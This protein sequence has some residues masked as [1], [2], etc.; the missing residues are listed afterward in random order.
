MNRRAHSRRKT[1]A[2]PFPASEPLHIEQLES[3]VYLGSTLDVLGYALFGSSLAFLTW[4][5]M[6]AA[7][8]GRWA[9]RGSLGGAP[10]AQAGHAN[11]RLTEVALVKPPVLWSPPEPLHSGVTIP[12][13]FGETTTS[14]AAR[15]TDLLADLMALD[16]ERPRL[17]FSGFG[18]PGIVAP[19]PSQEASG[20]GS[21]ADAGFFPPP[22]PVVGPLRAGDGQDYGWVGSLGKRR[23]SSAPLL[24]PA[25]LPS[26]GAGQIPSDLDSPGNNGRAGPGPGDGNGGDPRTTLA[27]PAQQPLLFE[28]N[29][30]QT[31]PSVR[32]VARAPGFNIFLRNTDAV[33]TIP[34][35]ASRSLPW[36]VLGVQF[37]NANPASVPVASKLQPGVS[38]YFLGNDRSHWATGVP[39]Y[40]QVEF[41]NLYP[42]INLVY[43]GSNLRQLEYDFVVA[44]GADPG[45]IRLGFQ[46]ATSVTMDGGGN[47]LLGTAAGT[48]TKR[49]P[50][51]YQTV[52]G[53]R[54]GVPTNYVMDTNGQVHL[55]VGS[56]DRR[57]PLVIDPVLSYSSYLGGS[58][59]DWGNGI[60]VDGRGDTYV[61]GQTESTNFPTAYPLYQ[62]RQGI[63]S[64]FVTKVDPSGSTLIYSTY[65]GGT[66]TTNVYSNPT[67]GGDSI[68]VDALGNAY[69][70]GGT[71]TDNFPTIG[72]S[73]TTPAG[74]FVTKLDPSGGLQNGAP[75]YSTYLGGV[76]SG[77]MTAPE[78]GVLGIAVDT[79]GDAYVTG[80]TPLDNFP[81]TA[82]AFQTRKPSVYPALSAFV[83]KFNPA[84]SALVYST[85]L[86]GS[87]NSSGGFGSDNGQGI[88]VDAAGNAYIT[89]NAQSTDFPTTSGAFQIT[90][91]DGQSAFVTKLNGTG[92][93]LVY[94]TFLGGSGYEWGWGIA[95]DG[96]GNAYVTGRTQSADFPTTSGAFQ[97]TLRGTED[98]FVTKLNGTG[99]APLV[100]STYLGG[101]GGDSGYGIAVDGLGNAYV[102]GSTNSTNFPTDNALQTGLVGTSS[103]DAFVTK[104]NATG[105]APVYSTY[106]GGSSDRHHDLGEAIAVDSGGSAYIT[107]STDST[108]FPTTPGAFEPMRGGGGD[109]FV[110]S[111]S[112]APLQRLHGTDS[113]WLDVGTAQVAPNTGTLRLSNPLDFRQSPDSAQ[114]DSAGLGIAPALVYNS[115]TVNVRPIAEVT[116]QFDQSLGLPT[117]IHVDLYWNGV[118]QGMGQ[119]FSTSG[120]QAGDIY[121]LAAELPA[122]TRVTATDRDAWQVI[123]TGHFGTQPDVSLSYAGYAQVVVTDSNDSTSRDD[124][125]FGPGWSLA[126]LNR[127]VFPSVGPA[128]VLMVYGDGTSSHFFTQILGSNNNTTI[129]FASPPDDFGTL[130]LNSINNTYT[131]TSK[132]QVK[133]NYDSTGLLKSIIDPHGLAVTFTYDATGRLLN[134]IQMPDSGPTGVVTTFLYNNGLLREID[135]PGGRTLVIARSGS[136]LGAITNPDGYVHTFL[137]DNTNSDNLHHVTQEMWNPATASYS[138]D[139][140]TRELSQVDRGQGVTLGITP[141]NI[142]GL[143]SPALFSGQAIASTTDALGHTTSYTLDIPGRITQLQRPGVL[144]PERWSRDPSGLVATHIDGDNHITVN[145]YSYGTGAGDLTETDYADGGSDHYQYDPVF[146][147]LTFRQDPL[148]HITSYTYDPMFGDLLTVTDPLTHVTSYTWNNGL[149]QSVVDPNVHTT[150][151]S[152]YP[153]TRLLSVVTDPRGYSTNYQYDGAGNATLTT[154]AR[155]NA[156]TTLYDKMRRLVQQTNADMGNYTYTY[157]GLGEMTSRQ[158]ALGMTTYNYDSRGWQTQVISARGK[159]TSSVY[160][161]AGN[162]TQ[163]IDPRLDAM[164]HPLYTTIYAYDNANRRTQV[165]DAAHNN[166][167]YVYDDADNLTQVIDGNSH[168]TTYSYDGRNRRTAVI[169]ALSHTTLYNY[170]KAGN[171]TK[172]TDPNSNATC[173]LYD[174]A[175]RRTA[176]QD[177]LGNSTTYAYDN[178]GN[179]TQVIGP[180]IKHP[181]KPTAVPFSTTYDYDQAN[182]RTHVTDAD[183]KLT[184]YNYD[185]VGNL[186][187]MIDPNGH[188]TLYDYDPVNRLTKVTDP[189]MDVTTTLYDTAGDVTKVIDANNHPITYGYDPDHHVL[190]VTRVNVDS[191]SVTFTEVTASAYDNAGNLTR[192]TDADGH[193]TQYDYDGLNRRTKVTDPLT[194]VSSTLYDPAG[195]VTATVDARGFTTLYAF[196]AANRM[197]KVTDPE[198]NTTSTVYDN[199]G[200][201]TKVIDPRLD[202]NHNPL[203]STMYAYDADN[204]RTQMIDAQGGVTTTVYDK[205]G[206]VKH[207]LYPNGNKEKESFKYNGDNRPIRDKDQK[208]DYDQDHYDKAGNVVRM[209]DG[210]GHVTTYQ[211]DDA[212]RRT[213][214]IDPNGHTTMYNY[215]K[216]G[217]LTRVTD[218]LGYSTVYSYDWANRQTSVTDRNGKVS[219]TLYDKVGNVLKVTD[220]NQNTMSY[221]YDADNRRTFVQEGT[222]TGVTTT[223]YDQVGNVTLVQDPKNNV[224]T[225]G[226]NKDDLQT[227]MTDPYTR[228][229]NYSYDAAKQL[230]QIT[231]QLG[232]MRQFQYSGN[233]WLVQETRTL[234]AIAETLSY[235]YDKDGNQ[236]FAGS[237][238]GSAYTFSY[239]KIDRLTQVQEPFGVGL[240]YTYD[241]ANRLTLVKDS[242]GGTLTSVYDNGGR[243]TTRKFDGPGFVSLSLVIGW[244]DRNDVATLLYNSSFDGTGR[245]AAASFDLYDNEQRPLHEKVQDASGNGLGEYTYAY[246]NGGRLSG[247]TWTENRGMPVTAAYGYD[248][249]NRLT[250]DSTG[251][252][253]N[254]YQ[255]D[256][257][258]NRTNNGFVPTTNNQLQNDYFGYTYIY[259]AVGNVS[260]KLGATDSWSYTYDNVNHLASATHYMNGTAVLTVSYLYDALGQRIETDTTQGGTT[261]RQRYAYDRGNIWA[262]LDGNNS[263]ALQ[264]RHFY[265]D[266]V[267]AVFA[268]IRYSSSGAGTLYFDMTDRQGSVRE[269]LDANQVVQKVLDYDAYGAPIYESNTGMSERYRFTGREW[270]ANTKLQY[271]R[272]RDYDPVTQ[273]WMQQ[274]TIGFQGGDYNLYRYVHNGPTNATD[275]SGTF[276][277]FGGLIG[278]G[279]GA[280]VNTAL[281]VGTALVTGQDITLGGVAGAALQGA[282]IGGVIGATGGLGL[283]GLAG[284][285][286]AAGFGSSVVQQGIDSRGTNISLGGALVSG[287]ASAVGTAVGGAAANR[288]G[289]SF[290]SFVASGFLGGA[291]GGAIGGA[292]QGAVQAATQGGS[293]VDVIGG[294]LRGAGSGAL[295]GGLQGAAGA[296]LAYGAFRAAPY[297]VAYGRAL[298]AELRSAEQTAYSGVPGEPFIRALGRVVQ[299]EEPGAGP[300]GARAS[301]VKGDVFEPRARQ[302]IA[303]RG[304]VVIET[305]RPRGALQEGFDFASYSGEGENAQLFIN[306]AKD[307]AGLVRPNKFSSFGLGRQRVVGVQDTLQRNIMLARSAIIRDVPEGATRTALLRQL[308]DRQAIVRII[309]GETTRVTQAT[310]QKIE[311]RSRFPVQREILR[312]PNE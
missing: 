291:S 57:F 222:L 52:N 168:G 135:E 13:H 180:R 189:L 159:S 289:A 287:V 138:Y 157:N 136:D 243:L 86:G 53:A 188:T 80:Q 4:D 15:D 56:Y 47:L 242:L 61:T 227:L 162:V 66:D 156:T 286:F 91:K 240:S 246:D 226:Y 194:N 115:D 17:P 231:D 279:L 71:N 50:V 266:G 220:P 117:G 304:E 19:Q 204:R 102:T 307:Y 10:S 179:L 49:I 165:T 310:L 172:V 255:Y 41:D 253:N 257:A 254:T 125:I 302:L 68:A 256:N 24:S 83:S 22:E 277:I 21:R 228:T 225:F 169:D 241:M 35:P 296:G 175:D 46:D 6:A 237:S 37:V 59:Q 308:D 7:W 69:I 128:G 265:R 60:A 210:L 145:S 278:A 234:G 264:A 203:Y 51:A 78:E 151:Y 239:D 18:D 212:N 93:G 219:A 288:L 285:G 98:A 252:L 32:F 262:D 297:A 177:A 121:L 88:A 299:G 186:T 9:G 55:A 201:V 99:T 200:N 244:T 29:Q 2:K 110:A 64:A 248:S 269:V 28:P 166:T 290:T 73:Q 82:G 301:Y 3:R 96:S 294:G 178:A 155:S 43:H 232:R 27:L 58:G 111:I 48:I 16:F 250:S 65:L 40:G 276:G 95:V 108:D 245:V 20:G 224:T 260:Q 14:D 70:G 140:V 34:N 153:G 209:T 122:A 309:G 133:W 23:A 107:G 190:T 163:V 207:V 39:H 90:L 215:D 84:G 181:R 112:E 118:R 104:L 76:L 229:V 272:S 300:S 45:A 275:P 198:G 130:T 259:D 187:Q 129:N 44:P 191:N 184:S 274:D 38:N 79:A 206:N 205:A 221:G 109:A 273:R 116:T 261:T 81:T 208:G 247:Q 216:V 105:T 31:D 185:K 134:T 63:D 251:Y 218:A 8:G 293:V 202:V 127:L 132:D 305:Q 271:N 174:N 303:D 223:Q 5:R 195:N 77:G 141:A 94:S 144:T 292:Y 33:L 270:D 161:A 30:G 12:D 182:N 193:A 268:E 217:N 139:P 298:G 89:G 171:L 131:Y 126:G 233:G 158:D 97:T 282:V 114:D 263:N 196:D 281:Y 167:G 149:L 75:L 113:Y 25:G 258:G 238:N 123:V 152:Y 164:S 147:H 192:V 211:Y 54:Q 92:T 249:A 173:Y 199:A 154:D 62:T 143:T 142:R 120:H 150:Q 26:D 176:M 103:G 137:Y 124:S 267:D 213:K 197:T 312:M 146:H 100:Y 106:L 311:A 306:E 170:D 101:S 295:L 72:A 160:D 1:T 230:T 280:L 236:T 148:G 119:D 283:A 183:G 235:G 87:T 85:Y 74:G 36:S 11:L 214:V 284:T 42:G 67:T